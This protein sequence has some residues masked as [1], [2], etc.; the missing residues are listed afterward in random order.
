[1]R[2]LRKGERHSW[3]GQPGHWTCKRCRVRVTG[4]D[5]LDDGLCIASLS[6]QLDYGGEAARPTRLDTPENLDRLPRQG[7]P[8]ESFTERV[9]VDRESQS[10]EVS[11]D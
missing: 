1:M 10:Q 11:D 5:G 2:G 4:S 9:N 8:G 6:S 3:M 7:R